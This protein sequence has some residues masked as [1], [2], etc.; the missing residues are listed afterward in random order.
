MI[1]N[2][3]KISVNSGSNDAD[4]LPRAVQASEPREISMI[5]ASKLL[6]LMSRP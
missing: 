1:D 6:D 5:A 2:A 3:G 4:T